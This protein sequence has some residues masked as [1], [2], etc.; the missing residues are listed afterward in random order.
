MFIINQIII[1]F[2]IF[3][4]ITFPINIIILKTYITIFI[5]FT[6]WVI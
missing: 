6:Y 2:K 1:P 4:F 3:T 5:T